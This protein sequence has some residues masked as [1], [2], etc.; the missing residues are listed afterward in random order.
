MIAKI[1]RLL[2]VFLLVLAIV[3]AGCG[4]SIAGTYVN[5]TDSDNCLV[6]KADGTYSVY[7][8]SSQLGMAPGKYSVNGKTIEFYI[9]PFVQRGTIEGNTILTGGKRYR[10]Q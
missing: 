2:V 10:R 9:G 1:P 8:G 4:T 5:E 6:L 3:T 7:V